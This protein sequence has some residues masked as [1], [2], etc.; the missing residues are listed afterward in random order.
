MYLV[1]LILALLINKNGITHSNGVSP[2]HTRRALNFVA[3]GFGSNLRYPILTELVS[4]YIY[5]PE[6]LYK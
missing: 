1:Y 3:L 4:I 5:N 6:E 2:P